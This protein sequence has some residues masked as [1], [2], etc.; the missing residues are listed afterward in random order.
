MRFYTEP[1]DTRLER[2]QRGQVKR[3]S[4]AFGVTL[5]HHYPVTYNAYAAERTCFQNLSVR[6]LSTARVVVKQY[7]EEALDDPTH[8][9]AHIHAEISRL[10]QIPPHP[11]IAPYLGFYVV[12]DHVQYVRAFVS[13]TPLPDLIRQGVDPLTQIRIAIQIADAVAYLRSQMDVLAVESKAKAKL[14]YA[15]TLAYATAS[16][17]AS[18]LPVYREDPMMPSNFIYD[19]AKARICLVD[20]QTNFLRDSL[21]RKW[22]RLDRA[23]VGLV[24]HP[25]ELF[26]TGAYSGEKSIVYNLA[27]LAYL[28][29]VKKILRV[30]KFPP[31]EI[32]D[33][34]WKSLLQPNLHSEPARRMSLD[35]WSSRLRAHYEELSSSSTF[36]EP[37]VDSIIDDLIGQQQLL[38]D[39][40][41]LSSSPAKR[42]KMG[43]RGSLAELKVNNS[44]NVFTTLDLS[45]NPDRYPAST[46][47]IMDEGVIKTL[48]DLRLI[49]K[50]ICNDDDSLMTYVKDPKHKNMLDCALKT[51]R[52]KEKGLPEKVK[53]I[54]EPPKVSGPENPPPDTI[55]C[56]DDLSPP[57][58]P[59][60]PYTPILA[61]TEDI[62]SWFYN[63]VSFQHTP[64]SVLAFLFL[65]FLAIFLATCLPLWI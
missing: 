6:G 1:I 4:D 38:D 19:E 52:A 51:K 22:D 60:T 20:W 53:R 63:L 18:D 47:L 8:D 39:S 49:V 11:S 10:A 33:P 16:L 57:G 29:C 36:A 24:Y 32:Q 65:I 31:A 50:A 15:A 28:V 37:S 58:T 42:L 41:A 30:R 2:M 21:R 17:T 54:L 64:H 59:T 25:P 45:W 48:V 12:G 14:P 7:V 27:V 43:R 3:K 46:A 40:K 5:F 9:L 26:R 34:F 61:P 62:T 55:I 23:N 56:T 35:E 44:H 13:G